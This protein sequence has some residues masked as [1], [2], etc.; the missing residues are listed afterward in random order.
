MA[1]LRSIQIPDF[2]SPLAAPPIPAETY[3][4]R[5]DAAFAAAGT[6]WLYVYAD[7]E[8]LANIMHL[9]GFEPRFEEAALLL[10]RTR[11]VLF[12]GNE[13]ID[14]A[15]RAGLPDL[16]PVLAQCFSLPGQDRS[17]APDLKALLGAAGVKKGDTVGV[18]GWKYDEEG[19]PET[20][21]FYV[22]HAQIRALAAAV[23]GEEG[24]VERTEVLLHPATGQRLTVDADQIAAFDWG[25]A[26]A[27]EAVWRVVSGT[28]PGQ[29]ELEAA[30][31]LGY[32]GEPLTAHVMLSSSGRDGNVVG[33][34]SPSG[35]I[36]NK[37]DGITCGIGFWGG[38]SARAGL[39]TDA[40]DEAFLDHASA[41]F[42][43]LVRWYDT[44][45]LGTEGGVLHAATVEALRA[46][47]LDAALNPGHLTS[48]DEWS[49]TP[50]RPGATE[51]LKSGMMIQVDVI[52]VPMTPGEALNCEDTVVFADAALRDDLAARH[53]DVWARIEARRA[54]VATEIGVEL[55]PC[56]LPLSNTPLCL[57]PFWLAPDRLLAAR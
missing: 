5:C 41:Y 21:G 51:T 7:R 57:A 48:Y 3:A 46:G 23:G 17:R 30:R 2:G 28:R 16:E 15:V 1:G 26:R 29:A 27:S 35:R 22:P 49:Q 47:G 54:F 33:L 8:H 56:I 43:A 32:A 39:L 50:V 24:L 52:P 10:G 44:A 38:L 55:K 19:D 25:A 53:P 12:V 18:V 37:G 4:A 42:R 20:R 11:R 9:T 13:S 34:A 31:A 45:D 14:Y 40:A 36:L 6:D